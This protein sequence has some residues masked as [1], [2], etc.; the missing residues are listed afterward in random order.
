MAGTVASCERQQTG[1][2]NLDD[3]FQAASSLDRL[4][5]LDPEETLTVLVSPPESGPSRQST[6]P[7]GGDASPHNT[8]RTAGCDRLKI[9][10]AFLGLPAPSRVSPVSG[11]IEGG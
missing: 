11:L 2:I 1:I 3:G 9:I 8:A 5:S 7:A 10:A 6:D 4:S